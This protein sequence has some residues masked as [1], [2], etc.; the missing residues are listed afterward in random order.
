[1]FGSGAQ[2]EALARNHNLQDSGVYM[3]FGAQYY[4]RHS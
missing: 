4:G 1:M 2:E 3:V